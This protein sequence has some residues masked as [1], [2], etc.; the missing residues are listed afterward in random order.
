ME[1]TY[2]STLPEDAAVS[3][4]EVAQTFSWVPD[5]T[6]SGSYSI[7]FY[8]SDGI[9]TDNE[10]LTVNVRDVD[11]L[12]VGGALA[13]TVIIDY[14]QGGTVSV[15]SNGVYTRHQ[16]YIPPFALNGT[17]TIIARPPKLTDIPAEEIDSIPSAV[18]FEVVDMESG[19]TF[20]DSVIL[21]IEYK[22]FEL[23]D[24]GLEEDMRIHF[25]DS[26]R[27]V[28]K[29][30]MSAHRFDYDNN[31]LTAK[32]THFTVFCALPLSSS[33]ADMILNKGWNIIGVPVEPSG[34]TDPAYLFSDDIPGFGTEERNSFIYSYNE[35]AGDWDIPTSIRNGT[36]Y[37]LYGFEK[38]PINVEGYE[39]T[40]D[41]STAL[42]YTNENG[43]HLLGNPYG[44]SINW[45]TDIQLG[46]GISS[47]IYMWTG[48][49]YEFYPD[50]GL[51]GNIDPWKGF[52][53]NT[54]TDSSIITFNYPGTS[55]HAVHNSVFAWR[56]RV[57][58]EVKEA[59]DTHNY[60]GAAETASNEHDGSDV[61][62]LSPLSD[63]YISV[64]FPH[65]DWKEYGGNFTQDIRPLQEEET[66]WR[67]VVETN[68]LNE[69]VAL[70]WDMPEELGDISKIEMT[71]LETGEKF[72]MTRFNNYSFWAKPSLSKGEIADSSLFQKQR[73]LLKANTSSAVVKREFLIIAKT[74][75]EENQKTIPDTYYM[76]QNYPNPFNRST[77][78][79]YGLPEPARVT[80]TIFNALGQE[81]KRLVNRDFDAG[82]FTIRW[83][84]TNS[85]GTVV[86]SGVYLYKMSAGTF[87]D[88]KKLLIVK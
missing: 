1:Y 71:D 3:F 37:I 87:D 5:F 67:M 38:Y 6:H 32:V 84:G 53:I 22:D 26:Q 76:S 46:S 33:S 70:R 69:N 12:T 24:T 30:L 50:G 54:T 2:T 77:T 57:K 47:I 42:S 62:E 56:I 10:P 86:S 13:D 14:S 75:V 16:V 45:D 58:G 21:T 68:C 65:D 34:R 83:D 36:G 40:G 63:E 73:T 51:T 74:G 66:S 82:E 19:Y 59:Y 18:A 41:V 60:L 20:N 88:T 15:D 7:R 61:Y 8:A 80:I 11:L 39:V 72:D 17:A 27:S 55:K 35:A 43:W 4:D 31:T 52:W 28:W 48:R 9:I 64:Y 29:R 78:I 81:I 23:P 44:V 25:W 85:A 49:Q 79:R